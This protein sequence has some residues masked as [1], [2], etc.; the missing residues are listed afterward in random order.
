MAWDF[1]ASLK[2]GIL[3]RVERS[4]MPDVL[5]GGELLVGHRLL[6]FVARFQLD[7]KAQGREIE[8]IL[9]VVVHQVSRQIACSAARP[10]FPSCIFLALRRVGRTSR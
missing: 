8:K 10:F 2:N 7:F 6:D 4:T 9:M 5:E 1:V 3:V